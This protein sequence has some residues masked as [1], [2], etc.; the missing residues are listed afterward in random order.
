V[1]SDGLYL[2]LVLGRVGLSLIFKKPN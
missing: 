2:A 1:Q